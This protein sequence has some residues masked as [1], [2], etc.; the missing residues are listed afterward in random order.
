MANILCGFH[1][2]GKS[3]S[4]CHTD[5]CPFHGPGYL[6]VDRSVKLK[7]RVPL[8]VCLEVLH[9]NTVLAKQHRT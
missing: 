5:N 2:D 6:E 4:L 1:F 3:Q 7:P 9:A 8:T